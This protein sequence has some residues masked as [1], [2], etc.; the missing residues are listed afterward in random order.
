[1]KR[2]KWNGLL[3]I[4]SVVGGVIGF[5]IGE[6]ML[7]R[8]EGTMHETVLMG[9]YFGQLALVTGLCCLLAE[10]IS[11]RL[12]GRS[13][14]LRYA[15]DGWKL[16]VPATL[17]MLFAAGALAQLIYGLQL[18]NRDKPQDYVLLLDISE[19]MT[20][21][22]PDKRS[23]KAAES[24]IRRMDDGKRVA[25][26]TFNERPQQVYPLTSLKGDGAREQIAAK[27]KAVGEPIGSTNIG[28]ALT[29][30]MR[31]M[32]QQR[33]PNRRAAVIL[34]SDGFSEVD[35]AKVLEP[36]R[37]QRTQVHTVGID[38]SEQEGVRLLQ[39]IASET[40]GTFHDVKRVDGITAAFD[41]IYLNGQRWHLMNERAGAAASDGYHGVLRVALV[42][43]LGSLLG[44]SLGIVFD[45][46]YLAQ[47]FAIGGAVAG[48][49]AGILLETGLQGSA[50]PLL[51]RGFADVTLA[52]VLSLSTLLV[53]VTDPGAG[54]GTGRRSDGFQ[55][56]EGRGESSLIGSRKSGT[57]R[58]QFR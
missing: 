26:Y 19:S 22:D 57:V 2:R 11:P 38:S 30:A 24:L 48:L 52:F 29:E 23:L 53:A 10:M 27:L 25:V 37:Q 9:L 21:T 32:E 7:D 46:R 42:L 33:L 4:M 51:A 40:G 50:E 55:G 39:S 35:T 18:G 28:L 56:R 45:N 49:I 8:W 15:R 34:I 13:W 44:L 43:L 16:L 20:S 17:L 54:P 31:H 41:E 3:T 36:Y 5:M 12:N 58:K 1:M 47:S 14:R 6:L